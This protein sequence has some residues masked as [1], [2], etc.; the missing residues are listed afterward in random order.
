MGMCRVMDCPQLQS[1]KGYD[2]ADCCVALMDGNR[3]R[4]QRIWSEPRKS[5]HVCDAIHDLRDCPWLYGMPEAMREE[6]TSAYKRLKIHEKDR[7]LKHWV[8]I[9]RCAGRAA[10][11]HHAVCVPCKLCWM[12]Q[13]NALHVYAV[14]LMIHIACRPAMANYNFLSLGRIYDCCCMP[15]WCPYLGN[16]YAARCPLQQQ[17]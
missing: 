7:I 1:L 8:D 6:L 12:R 5:C 16:A 11:M 17:A 9:R 13:T 2:K 10:S 4:V 15:V 14:R 3:A